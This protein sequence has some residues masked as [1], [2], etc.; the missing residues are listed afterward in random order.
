MKILSLF[1]QRSLFYI[2]KHWSIF[3]YAAPPTGYFVWWEFSGELHVKTSIMQYEANALGR[4]Y[5]YMAFGEV[6]SKNIFLHKSREVDI[7][8]SNK[9]NCR[10]FYIKKHGNIWLW[11]DVRMLT[12]LYRITGSQMLVLI[13]KICLPR[14]RVGLGKYIFYIFIYY[15]FI[16]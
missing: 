16:Y 1:L 8:L 4:K 15:I 12:S 11:C 7:L 3:C 9:W 2:L 10:T 5:Y 6:C 13:Y 14:V